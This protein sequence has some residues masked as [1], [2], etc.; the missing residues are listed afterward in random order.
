ML[1]SAMLKNE[2]SKAFTLI[3]LLVVIAIIAVLISMLLPAL[4]K[5][6]HQ[7]KVVACASNMKQT[8]NAIFMYNIQYKRGLQNYHPACK[9]WGQEWPGA[10]AGA[11]F[12]NTTTI[13]HAWEEGAAIS[14]YWR[15]YLLQS[16]LIGRINPTTGAAID[17][18]VLG[19]S[20]DDSFLYLPVNG[21][22]FALQGNQNNHV[23]TNIYSQT[24]R[25]APPYIWYG[26]GIFD[27]YEVSFWRGS[28]YW[29][30][31]TADRQIVTRY[32]KHRGPLL[33]CP[34]IIT[35]APAVQH[36]VVYYP[37]HRPNWQRSREPGNITAYASRNY[38]QNVGFNDG[39][40]KYYEGRRGPYDMF[41]MQ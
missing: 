14:S 6:R 22:A 26:P 38:A 3:E 37:T 34:M 9:W 10:K 28:F 33:A 30:V 31:E 39:S 17:A 25:R 15:G 23:E 16:G 7:A 27:Y 40:V 8:I 41:R 36:N 12:T 4:Q 29:R 19:C 18:S 21:Y 5:V 35:P 2:R 1:T 20:A 24:I 13:N 32:K 11:H